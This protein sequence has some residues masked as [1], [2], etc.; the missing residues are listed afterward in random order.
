MTPEP[1]LCRH[2]QARPRSP[3]SP[4]GLCGNCQQSRHIRALYRTGWKDRPPGWNDHLARLAARARLKLPLFPDSDPDH[5]PEAHPPE[6]Q[7]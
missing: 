5:L 6:A 7:P 1:S 4:Q 2:C 3:E